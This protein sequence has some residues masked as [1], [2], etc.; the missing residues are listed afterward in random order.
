MLTAMCSLLLAV[1]LWQFSSN[2]TRVSM[3]EDL[4]EPG[5]DSRVLVIAPHSDDETLGTGALVHRLTEQGATV[6]V[7]IMTNGDGFGTAVRANY[8][9]VFARSED[10]IRLG[11][12]RQQ[13]TRAALELLGLDPDS[14]VFL[15]YPDGGLYTLW[16][17]D[18]WAGPYASRFTKATESPYE[19]CYTTGATYSGLSVCADLAK[20]ITEF[21]PTHV[22]YPHPSDSN[23]DH[24]ATYNFTKLVLTDLES[25]ATQYLYLVHRGIWPLTLTLGVKAYLAPP[26]SLING[27]VWYRLELNRTEFML[28]RQAI[29][30]YRTQMKVMEPK[31]LAFARRNELFASYPDRDLPWAEKQDMPLFAEPYLLQSDPTMDLLT[32]ILKGAGDLKALH[33]YRLGSTGDI[34]FRLETRR[35][36]S[37]HLVYSLD[38]FTFG[39]LASPTRLCVRW[40]Q[41]ESVVLTGPD[42]SEKSSRA[43]Q[44]SS[45]GSTL[46]FLLPEAYVQDSDRIFI[47]FSVSERGQRV[48]NMAWRVYRLGPAWL[49][50]ELEAAVGR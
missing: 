18:H 37:A 39:H 13:E 21:E 31:L 47:G 34:C 24:L 25:T 10:Y 5:A 23:S 7:V 49:D 29:T 46:N 30:E 22:F 43:I 6:L 19:D 42:Q 8:L 40:Q 16:S 45:D 38:M 11:K 33:G 28:K 9:A 4:P 20:I 1:F 14:A 44:V 32:P 3:I 35:Q 41:G 26:R 15:G 2:N 48:D 36:L 17:A 50:P 12:Q 27:S